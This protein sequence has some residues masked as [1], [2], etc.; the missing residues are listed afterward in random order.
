MPI[1]NAK[2]FNTKT[3]KDENRLRYEFDRF[4]DGERV[5]FTKLFSKAWDKATAE[6]WGRKKDE[7]LELSAA[8]VK[9]KAVSIDEAILLFLEEKGPTLKS[10]PKIEHHFKMMLEFYE[11]KPLE[12]L[13]D[14]AQTMLVSYQKSGLSLSTFATRYSYLRAACRYAWR[15]L[16]IDIAE[17][18]KRFVV[19]SYNNEVNNTVDRREFIMICRQCTD[20]TARAVMRIAFYTGMRRGECLRIE[21]IDNELVVRD[22]KNGDDRIL[23]MSAKIR[24]ALKYRHR[25]DGEKVYR[26]FKKA[27]KRLGLDSLR[28]H[29]LRHSFASLLIN[30]GADSDVVGDILGHR[31]RKSTKRY[32]HRSMNSIAKAMDKAWQKIPTNNV[33]QFPK[34]VVQVSDKAT[35]LEEIKSA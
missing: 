6:K 13:E 29:D 18:G 17:P 34:K 35:E 25:I 12:N 4:I 2:V 19:P 22:T 7:E 14:V 11:G 27:V 16:K 20:I 26:E 23:P 1:Y 24:T 8:G 21:I 32:T 33:V 15:R 5:R 10:L 30:N 31:D 3:K 9:R 28:V